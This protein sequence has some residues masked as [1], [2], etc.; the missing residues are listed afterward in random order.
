MKTL[1]AH[2]RELAALGDLRR[3]MFERKLIIPRSDWHPPFPQIFD[4][5]MIRDFRSCPQKAWLDHMC[6][7]TTVERS[8]DLIAG[9]AFARGIEVARNFIFGPDRLPTS[10]GVAKGIEAL[11]SEYGDYTPPS[12]NPKTLDRMIGALVEYFDHYGTSIDP[13]KLA[14]KSDGM[15][16][17]EFT[18]AVPIPGTRHPETGDE[19]LYAIRL[20]AF[21]YYR[22][23]PF[24]C[25]EKTTKQLGDRWLKSWD[26]R[27]QFTG[28]VWGLR[29]CGIEVKGF[30]V[31]GISIMKNSYGHAEVITYRPEWAVDR[32]L[33][34]LKRD[35]E[36]WQRCWEE[37]YYDYNLDEACTLYSGC[38]FKPLCTTPNPQ[39]W[40]SQYH[41]R[42][43]D[44]LARN[45]HISVATNTQ[46][47]AT[48]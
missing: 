31:R 29:E 41:V 32:W 43:W 45:P 23:A 15:P 44:P 20:D 48:P 8:P 12:N 2:E 9:A 37:G 1:T 4:A 30:I 11:I 40:L 25:D 36:R 16:K 27:S 19:I 42:V 6:G 3:E 35:I 13:F 28:Y 5:T 14:L 46:Q 26:L 24:G 34:Q 38:P 17:V 22:D 18:A 39:A 21:G 7:L 47:E 10:E 33:V